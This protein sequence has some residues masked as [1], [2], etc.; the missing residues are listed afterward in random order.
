MPA[1]P[2]RPAVGPGVELSCHSA[3]PGPT[4]MSTTLDERET[5]E[6]PVR[7]QGLTWLVLA[8]VTLLVFELTADPALAVAAGCLKFGWEGLATA[9]WLRRTDPDRRRGRVVARFYTAGAFWNV[10]GVATA[11]SFLVAWFLTPLLAGRRGL[12]RELLGSF[13]V[14][15]FAF[16]ISGLLSLSAVASAWRCRVKVWLGPEARWARHRGAWPP[17]LF[18][19]GPGRFNR[20]ILIVLVALLSVAIPAGLIGMF[21]AM[22]AVVRCIGPRAPLLP[23]MVAGIGVP[24]VVLYVVGRTFIATRAAL[25][26]RMGAESPAECWPLDDPSGLEHGPA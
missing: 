23:F 24:I 25:L 26:G 22:A 1:A 17:S 5:R 11:M 3:A 12:N 19:A 20:V 18:D 2:T 7:R 8:L 10:A 13:L 14:A 9:R 16:V 6:G 4:T 15:V 21:T